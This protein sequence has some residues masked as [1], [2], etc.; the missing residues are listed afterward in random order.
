MQYLGAVKLGLDALV[1]A[2][3]TD[4]SSGGMPPG[5]PGSV[6]I[7]EMDSDAPSTALPVSLVLAAALYGADAALQRPWATAE[8]ASAAQELLAALAA[9]LPVAAEQQQRRGSG[10][11]ALLHEVATTRSGRGSGADSAFHQQLPA[12]Q[13]LVAL[14]LPGALQQL[15]P[16]VAA[17]VEHG[18]NQRTRLE[19][20]TGESVA[21]SWAATTAHAVGVSSVGLCMLS[22][23]SDARTTF[24]APAI[25]Q[26]LSAGPSNFERCAATGQLAWLL[27]QLHG[28]HLNAAVP[29]ALQLVL[30][31]AEDTFPPAQ[32][33]ALW[34][35][36]HLAA[37]GQ[38]TDLR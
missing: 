17:K 11:G 22:Q 29:A 21:S 37:A 8:A 1:G 30:A 18:R 26:H 13:Q 35:L 28:R 24:S 20:Y 36:Q 3:S 34:A 12:V 14:A 2:S 25:H 32:A 5:P 38:A 33:C 23:N 27:R 15:R 7:E 4:G 19:P 31:A 9:Q 10:S 6:H 16:V